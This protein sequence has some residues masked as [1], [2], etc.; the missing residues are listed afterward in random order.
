MLLNKINS[1]YLNFITDDF[2]VWQHA[3]GKN[4]ALEHGYALDDSARA[5]IV[6]L[7]LKNN[8]KADKCLGYLESSFEQG[9]MIGFFDEKRRS[10]V[11]PSSEDAFGL[12]C[13]A[14]AY[15]IL[16]NFEKVRAE[17][18][19]S[20]L[21]QL[22]LLKSVNLRPHAYGL[23]SS[24]L[25]NDN[26]NSNIHL[27]FILSK[28]DKKTSWFEKDLRYANAMIPYSLLK[29][30]RLTG[31]E[32]LLKIATETLE[33]LEDVQR[34]GVF[35]APVGNRVWYTIGQKTYDN[36]GQQPIDTA[37]MILAYQ[38][39]AA[40]TSDKKYT[41]KAL[42]WLSWFHGFNIWQIPLADKSDGS[43][44]DGLDDF[45]ANPNCGAESTI[46]YLWSELS[47]ANQAL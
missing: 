18:L 46:M 21:D 6:Y 2:G 33:M 43:C 28:Y 25:M 23:I 37:F 17:Q 24:S 12:A 38:E 30:Y 11:S 45:G 13:W 10:I 1:D 34:I 4:I 3:N 20:K 19:L 44:K 14:L 29:K 27:N 36:Y 8:E 32:K 41:E 5:L 31:E 7:L 22:I 42:R 16:S 39:I 15:C 35:P 26:N 47:L 40:I 9:H